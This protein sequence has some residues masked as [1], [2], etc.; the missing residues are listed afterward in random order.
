MGSEM[1][2]RD[3]L[4]SVD[5]ESTNDSD[6]LNRKAPSSEGAF[7]CERS[8]Y[9]SNLFTEELSDVVIARPKVDVEV[10]LANPSATL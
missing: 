2:I 9:R 3:S 7:C 1:C 5:L 8:S 4:P 10:E 6:Q